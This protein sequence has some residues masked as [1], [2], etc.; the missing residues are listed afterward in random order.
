MKE[1]ARIARYCLHTEPKQRPA[2]AEVVVKLE[3][4]LSQETEI[5]NSD[6][7]EEGF[8]YKLRSLF[9]GKVDDAIESKYDFSRYHDLIR[10]EVDT[11]IGSSKDGSFRTFTYSEL[12]SATNDFMEEVLSPTLNESIYKG[13]V[14]E[15]TY[16]PT[17]CGI[18]LPIYVRKIVSLSQKKVIKLKNFNHSKFV[19]L[20]GYCCNKEELF[21]VYEF[22]HGKSLDKY[23]YREQAT[24]SLSWLARL[25]IAIGAAESL[26]YLHKRNQAAYSQ[27]KTSHILVDTDFNARLSDFSFVSYSFQIDRYY[28]APEWFRYRADR[29]ESLFQ[30]EDTFVSLHGLSPA[31][32]FTMK[33]EIYAFG[34]V[35][36]EILTGMMVY[37]EERPVGKENLV[38][39]AMPLLANEVNLRMIMDPQLQHNDCPPKGAFK[40]AQLVLNCL[41]GKKDE[42]PSMEEI[43]LVLNQCYQEEIERV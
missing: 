3:S 31:D 24:T 11:A 27:F 26:L 28:A 17:K 36:L 13:W 9:T 41:H 25:N 39:W 40:L 29:F 1:F 32:D 15:R 5:A 18:G 14:D 21:C 4:I 19:K 20:L 42:R 16:A 12:A 38:E 30:E 2:M 34:V 10:I 33:N 35:L 37:D 23:L 22:I 7:S 8:I 43:L 6:D